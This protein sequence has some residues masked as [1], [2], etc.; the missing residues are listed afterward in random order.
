SRMAEAESVFLRHTQCENCGSSDANSLYSDGHQ[1]CFSCQHYVAGDGE[2]V[3]KQPRKK[4]RVEGLVAGEFRP[5]MARKI[6]EDTARKFGYT[7][8]DYKGKTVQIAPYH[9]A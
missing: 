5:L 9:D 1:F 3:D 7:V 8:G 6:T 4:S 2:A